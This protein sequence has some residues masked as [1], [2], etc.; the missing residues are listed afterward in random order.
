MN[1]TQGGAKAHH[2]QV[3]IAL[4]EQ[5]ALKTGVDAKHFR[6][7]TEQFF[8]SL[9]GNACKFAVCPHFP[10]RIFVVD[11]DFGPGQ[12]E[13][14]FHGVGHVVEVAHHI[15]ALTGHSHHGVVRGLNAG[16]IARSLYH[17]CNGLVLTVGQRTVVYGL[18]GANHILPDGLGHHLDGIGAFQTEIHRLFGH[19]EFICHFCGKDIPVGLDL[20]LQFCGHGKHHLTVARNSIVQFS[21]IETCQTQAGDFLLLDKQEAGQNLDGIGALLVDVVARVPAVQAF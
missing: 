13:D 7:F 18:Y 8:V 2:I 12:Q 5:A 15:A 21:A 1:A 11:G 19:V 14:S 6:L 9:H 3:G 4:R 17:P 16:D 20:F 10:S